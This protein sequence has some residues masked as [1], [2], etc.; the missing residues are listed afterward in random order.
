VFGSFSTARRASARSLHSLLPTGRFIRSRHTLLL[1][2]IGLIGA[3][4]FLL[5][6]G[7]TGLVDETPAIFAASARQMA[8]S[9][10]W[11]IPQVNGLPRYDKP[12]LIYWLMGGLYALPGSDQWDPLGSWA[13]RLPSALASMATM[14]ALGDTLLRWPPSGLAGDGPPAAGL[15]RVATA[16]TAALAFALGPLMLVWGR[17]EV[18]DALFTATLA[19]SL[20]LAWRTFAAERGPWWPCWSVLALAVLSKGPVAIVLFALSLAL[21]WLF[22]AEAARLLRRLR[23]C[24]GFALTLVLAAPWFAVALLREGKPYWDSFFGYHNLQR[25]SKVVNN[26]Q[27]GPW[28]FFIVL[29]LAS[30]PFTPLLLLSL[31]RVLLEVR[32][33]LAVPL[34][35]GRFATAWLLAVLLFFSLSATKLPS[36]WLVATPAAALLVALAPFN[37]RQP[38]YGVAHQGHQGQRGLRLAMAASSA[39]LVLFSAALALAPQWLPLINDPTLP[40]LAAAVV[41]RPWL[42]LGAAVTLAAALLLSGLATNR[43]TARLLQSQAA[44]LLLVPLVLL[45]VWQIGDQLRGAPIRQLAAIARAERSVAEPLAMVGLIKPSLHFYSQSTVLFEGRSPHA[46]VNLTDRLRAESRPGLQ[47]SSAD[48]QPTLLLV[49]DVETANKPHWQTMEGEQLAQAGPYRLWRLDRLWLEQRARLLQ[50]GGIV[51]TW[52]NPR[53]EMI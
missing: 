19:L 39:L 41:R 35:L 36:Y 34:S 42:N 53:P 25:F 17:T 1:I 44:L 27:Q 3:G 7:Q 26:H 22:G 8:E 24:P 9:G 23:P 40:G 6:L 51:P 13:A 45:P 29:V 47:P 37:A 21:F 31:R 11:L 4:V 30:L 49:I 2:L 38:G 18:S 10:D 12:P 48:R 5:G 52:R 15:G 46:L 50:Q 14:A 33:P 32:I 16:I 20:L 28:Y 43:P